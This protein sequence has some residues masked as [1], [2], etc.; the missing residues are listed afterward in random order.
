MF[1]LFIF[2]TYVLGPYL[3]F[4]APP[5]DVFVPSEA[6]WLTN[7]VLENKLLSWGLV[8]ATVAMP[9]A[10]GVVD[11][12]LDHRLGVLVDDYTALFASSKLVSASSLDAIILNVAV[13][14]LIPR[15]VTLRQPD[16]PLEM[17]QRIGAATLL[18]P[19]VGPALY[20]ALRPPL[21]TSIQEEYFVE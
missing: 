17:A 18:L 7:N 15:D 1:I 2:H 11:A 14:S 3:T 6:G 16:V 12:I 9:F 20:I 5:R 13:A 4:R 19:F 21:P 10:V 8:A